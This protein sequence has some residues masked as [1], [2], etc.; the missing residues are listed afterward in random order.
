MEK[1]LGVM[2]AERTTTRISSNPSSVSAGEKLYIQVLELSRN[3]VLVPG[4]P[5][6][7]FDIDLTGGHTNNSLGQTP[8]PKF[9]VSSPNVVHQGDLL[10]L[11]DKLGPKTFKYALTVSDV[12]SRSKEAEHLTSKNS[13]EVAKPFAKIY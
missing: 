9:D 1:S 8:W 6:L 11:H 13:H 12:A 7:C 4:L 3:N 10:F 5:V 2:K